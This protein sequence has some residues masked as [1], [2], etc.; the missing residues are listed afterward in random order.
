MLSVAETEPGWSR[1][2]ETRWI[3]ED[4]SASATAT[5]PR[6]G[7]GECRRA[8]WAAG[9]AGARRGAGARGAHVVADLFGEGREGAVL[10]RGL[11]VHVQLEGEPQWRAL[12]V[13]LPRAAPAVS[14]PPPPRNE[15]TRRVPH[16]VLVGHAASLSQAAGAAALHREALNTPRACCARVDYAAAGA[17]RGAAGAADQAGVLR[18]EAEDDAAEVDRDAP[19][20]RRH[21]AP[22]EPHKEVVRAGVARVVRHKVVPRPA[23]HHL[24]SVR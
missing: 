2:P 10:P 16:P 7:G 14:P 17:R 22:L 21:R 8:P 5:C 18:H 3:S 1:T 24:H 4:G 23:V 11:V 12:A 15:W 20:A 6:R 9:A 19:A 13:A